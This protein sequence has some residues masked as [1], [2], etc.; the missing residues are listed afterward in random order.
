M[1]GGAGASACAVLLYIPA[2][3]TLPRD[4][5]GPDVIRRFFLFVA[6][7][8]ALVSAQ[9]T[10]SKQRLSR[11]DTLLES[12]VQQNKI[13]GAVALILQDGKPAYERA[14]GWADK[15]AGKRMSPDTIFRIASQ[16]KA[17]T[18]TAVLIL[19]EE[20]KIAIDESVGDFIPTFKKTMVEEAGGVVV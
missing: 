8:T 19:V 15:E 18:S 11:I 7:T 12:Y 6:L 5:I 14:F 3:I 13:A 9:T 10:L 1:W 17:I 16:T 20:G 2:H 4:S